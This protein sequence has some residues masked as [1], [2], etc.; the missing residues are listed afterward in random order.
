MSK[1]ISLPI[2]T[3]ALTFLLLNTLIM[4]FAVEDWDGRFLLPLLPMIFI[5]STLGVDYLIESGFLEPLIPKFF[6]KRNISA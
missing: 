2:K 6:L 5:F 4:G 3:F 1:K